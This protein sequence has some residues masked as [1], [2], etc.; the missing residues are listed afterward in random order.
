MLRK[1]RSAVVNWREYAVVLRMCRER[2]WLWNRRAGKL[3]MLR[4]LRRRTRRRLMRLLLW[5][6]RGHWRT[7][8]WSLQLFTG[9]IPL[10]LS[11]RGLL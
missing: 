5:L 6:W 2:L 1:Q 8:R 3:L 9:R 11:L 4:G 10:H 7:L